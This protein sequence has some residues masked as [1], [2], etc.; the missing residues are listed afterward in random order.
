MQHWAKHYVV[1]CFFLS[2]AFKPI[3]AEGYYVVCRC[4]EQMT[5]SIMTISIMTIRITVKMQHL[6]K[7]L[8]WVLFLLRVSLKPIFTKWHNAEYRYADFHFTEC[9]Y[10][11]RHYSQWLDAKQ[12]SH[13]ST[14]LIKISTINLLL[15]S[16]DNEW[17]V[18]Q[19][20]FNSS[21]HLKI[22][23]WKILQGPLL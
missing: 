2:V 19:N 16:K 7:T 20:G 1:N 8:C 15:V 12:A 5:F 13:A 4:A 22:W 18:N 14:K 6:S 11:V 10:A 3:I 17:Q 21:M 9:C 23:G